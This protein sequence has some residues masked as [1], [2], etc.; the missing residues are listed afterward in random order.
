MVIRLF[1]MA[2]LC[3]RCSYIGELK[4][5]KP[6]YGYND[7]RCPKC[8]S[9]KN[10]HNRKYM[11]MFDKRNEEQEKLLQVGD[12]IQIKPPHAWAYCILMVSEVK[13]FGCQ[14]YIEI[15]DKGQAYIRLNKNEYIK[16]GRAEYV[17]DA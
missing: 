10:E 8:G 1:I 7:I 4:T 14:A 16:V 12:I 9:T 17:P 6:C 2:I 15:P 13:S 5:Y 11:K 3:E